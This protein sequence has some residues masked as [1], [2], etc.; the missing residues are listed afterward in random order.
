MGILTDVFIEILGDINS[1]ISTV[2]YGV[3]F[4]RE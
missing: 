3:Q 2:E 1:I 4:S